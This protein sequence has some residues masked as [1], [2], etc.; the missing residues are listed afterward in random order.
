MQCRCFPSS[1][2]GPRIV[3]LAITGASVLAFFRGA[4]EFPLHLVDPVEV[5]LKE[6]PSE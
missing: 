1:Q 4:S 5:R 6:A 3:A 2:G